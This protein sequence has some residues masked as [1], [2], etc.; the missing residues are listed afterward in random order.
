MHF[1]AQFNKTYLY[2]KYFLVVE[3]FHLKSRYIVYGLQTVNMTSFCF[4][5]K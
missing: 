3:P 1:E 5:V 2:G 4:T